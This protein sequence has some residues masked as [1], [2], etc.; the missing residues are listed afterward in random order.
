M[1]VKL[2]KIVMVNIIVKE[3]TPGLNLDI[4]LVHP[5]IYWE[6]YGPIMNLAMLNVNLLFQKVIN[7]KRFIHYL[8]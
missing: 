7:N 3:E 1:V 8:N 5:M 6:I 2:I 4:S